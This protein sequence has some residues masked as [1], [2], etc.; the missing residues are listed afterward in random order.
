QLLKPITTWSPT[1][2]LVT[3]DPTASTTPAPSWPSTTGWGVG[4]PWSRITMSVWQTPVATTRT[5]TSSARGG[6]MESVS[7]RIGVRLPRRTAAWAVIGVMGSLGGGKG[8]GLY[9][10]ARRARYAPQAG[11]RITNIIGAAQ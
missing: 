2:T 10:L 9:W 7:I 3:D 6:S 1:S 5:S 4:T 8:Q 11:R